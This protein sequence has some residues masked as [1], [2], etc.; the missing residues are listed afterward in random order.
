MNKKARNGRDFLVYL[1]FAVLKT[2]IFDCVIVIWVG[3]LFEGGGSVT[4]GP[5]FVHAYDVWRIWVI[6]LVWCLHCSRSV[7]TS[8]R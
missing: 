5:A 1:L 2:P 8:R 3:T 4:P 7:L 6:Q